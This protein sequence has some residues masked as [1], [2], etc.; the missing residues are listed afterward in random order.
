MTEEEFKKLLDN[1]ENDDLEFRAELQRIDEQEEKYRAAKAAAAFYNTRGGKIVF[2]V[3]EDGKKRTPTGLERIQITEGNFNTQI[4][5]KCNFDEWPR[6]EFVKYRSKDF[7]VVYCPKGPKPPYCFEKQVLIRRGSNN[8]PATEEE[9]AR[10]YRDRST[11]SYDRSPV[12]NATLKDIDLTQA[13]AYL[14][15]HF[16]LSGTSSLEDHL[17]VLHNI[18]ILKIKNQNYIPTIAGILLFGKSP[19]IFLPQAKIKA[20]VKLDESSEKW[21]DIAEIGGTIFEQITS[22][23]K[24]IRRNSRISAKIVGFKRIEEPQ[25]PLAALREAIINALVHRDYGDT[26][27]TT[28]VKIR[29]DEVIISN[30]GS[31]IPPLTLEVVLGGHFTPRTRNEIIA[32]TILKLGYMER[33]GRGLW[34]I[35][36]LM[37]KSSLP[38]PK[39]KEEAGSFSMTLNTKEIITIKKQ[40]II[41]DEI[42]ESI[43]LDEDQKKILEVVEKVEKARFKDFE[44]VLKK[45][46]GAFN[47]KLEYLLDTKIIQ[48]HPPKPEKSPKA[49]YTIHEKF[50]K[51]EPGDK[52]EQGEREISEQRQLL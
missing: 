47:K 51:K 38:E 52:Q 11:E 49:F 27:A 6:F 18:G 45:T 39:F 25:F 5:A 34:L 21:D 23:E 17:K 4:R 14:N 19:Q 42:W 8:L 32:E 37:N 13:N 7:L 50:S 28:I 33:R 48:R 41:P 40:I 29:K 31:I 35:Q 44:R 16:D 15:K 12:E 30:P 20:D 2:G 22:S 24:F 3:K 43:K 26:T 9:I 10:M 46:R 1:F 36:H